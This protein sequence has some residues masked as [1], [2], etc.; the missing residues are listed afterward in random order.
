M[1]PGAGQAPNGLKIVHQNG[2]SRLLHRRAG[3]AKVGPGIDRAWPGARGAAKGEG[4]PE[5]D[6][7]VQSKRDQY[8]V[9][10]RILFWVIV[11]AASSLAA[12]GA[13]F[14]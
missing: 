1:T 6:Q 4:M 10:T 13:I 8:A 5:N 7:F 12:L 3:G 11:A 14:F 2:P 9:F